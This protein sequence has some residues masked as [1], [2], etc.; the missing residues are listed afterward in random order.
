MATTRRWITRTSVAIAVALTGATPALTAPDPP[1]DSEAAL[2]A[3]ATVGKQLGVNP[4]TLT[5]EAVGTAYYPNLDLTVQ[6]FKIADPKGLLH[7][8]A[9]DKALRPADPRSLAADER[10]KRLSRFGALDPAL[11]ERIAQGGKESLAVTIWIRDTTKRRWD[12]PEARGDSLPPEQIDELYAGVV[13]ARVAALKPLVAPVV[14]RVR[15]YDSKA[16]ADELVPII[17]A[18]LSAEALQKLARDPGIEAIYLS[19]PSQPELDIAKLT[20]GVATIHGSGILGRGVRVSDIQA[21]AGEVEANS[22]YLRPVVQDMVNLCPGVNQHSTAVAGAMIER[23]L[24]W[25]GSPSGEEGTSPNIELRS[26]GSCQTLGLELQSASTRGVRWGARIINLT[27]GHDRQ[28]V[29][30]DLDRFY[31]EI[32]LNQWRTVTKAAGNTNGPNCPEN[33]FDGTTPSPGLAY[34]VIAVGGFDDRNTVNWSDDTIYDCSSTINPISTHSDREK[35][36]LSAPAVNIKVVAPG[37]ANLLDVTGTSIA[38]PIVAG[39]SALLIEKNGR[40]SVWPEIIRATLMATADHNIEGATRLS[41]IDGAGGMN[42]AAAASLIADQQHW[43]GVRYSCNGTDPLDL[44]TLSV[45]PRTRHRVVLSWDSD[46]AFSDYSREPSADIDLRVRDANGA[47]VATSMSWDGTN[48]IVEFDSWNAGT[49][50]LQ[51]VRFRCDLPTWLG[52]AWHTLPIPRTAGSK[53]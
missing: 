35:P 2:V 48:E 20:T 37:P 30:G 36:E 39:T 19:L 46:P 12:R 44:A 5:V 45:S 53:Q 7:A 51:A 21:L 31:D 17:G 18:T 40:L 41:D 9:V 22:L 32:V 26:G 4:E 50:T 49:Y 13:E 38:A 10:A 29:L 33:P 47:T 42:A 8:I 14:E 11:A 15:A 23:R 24:N 52:W 3:L 43:N 27:W 34:N 28:S 16:S 1:A 6:S 25:F